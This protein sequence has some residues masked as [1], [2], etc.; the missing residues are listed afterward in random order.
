M[1]ANKVVIE[2]STLK[3]KLRVSLIGYIVAMVTGY[4]KKMTI[5]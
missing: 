1:G 5:F 2:F 3:L 4:V